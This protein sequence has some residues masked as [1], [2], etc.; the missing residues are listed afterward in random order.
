MGELSLVANQ[1][2]LRSVGREE[3]RGLHLQIPV[4]RQRKA[5]LYLARLVVLRG[6]WLLR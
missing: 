3:H 6:Y 2:M 5:G 4:D 1:T